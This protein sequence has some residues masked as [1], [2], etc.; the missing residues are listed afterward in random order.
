MKV[1]LT[2][3][4]LTLTFSFLI[5]SG[6]AQL[7][8]EQH[9]SL[10]ET[11]RLLG[12]K[13]IAYQESWCPPREDKGWVMDCSNTVRYIYQAVFGIELPRVASSQYY[14]L[15]QLGQITYAPRL[16]DGSVDQEALVSQMRSGDLLF[17]E[18][19]YDIKRSPPITHVMIYLGRTADGTAK[20]AGS[21]TRSR[22]E[23]TDSGGVNIYTFNANAPMGGVRDFW[24]NT[25]RKGRFVGFGRVI[26]ELP[27][28][29][30][31]RFAEAQLPGPATIQT[32]H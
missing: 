20:M 25:V 22:G 10:V 11:A 8:P 4:L 1:L 16:R 13:D 12:R 5:E 23:T 18:W 3:C 6:Q 17:W 26:L 15:K 14:T 28:S 21:A 9:I 19:T 24:G 30:Q 7:R 29:Q 32:P 2:S 27:E 31:P